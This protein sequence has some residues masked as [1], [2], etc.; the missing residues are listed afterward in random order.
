LAQAVAASSAFPPVFSPIIVETDPA[1]WTDAGPIE[2][3]DEL[4]HRIV[5]TDGGVYDNMGLETLLRK[6]DIIL[7]SDAGAPF[8]IDLEPS[9][10]PLQMGRVRDILID[11][12]RAL[13]KRWLI[14]D[15]DARRR[16]G[17]Y[18][19]LDTQIDDYSD[20]LAIAKDNAITQS[21]ADV[22]TRLAGLGES[23]EGR[24][25]NWGY[26]LADAAIRRRAALPL[27]RAAGLP[28]DDAPLA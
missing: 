21:L 11:Q 8:K 28:V 2:H 9:E 19:G 6:V 24:L 3:L 25:I 16:Q 5:L 18:W 13:R 7:V 27:A 20:P 1:N 10:T 17:G 12:T 22:P 15:F 26:A 4:R 14:E 23:T